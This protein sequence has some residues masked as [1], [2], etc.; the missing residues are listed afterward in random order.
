[1][2]IFIYVYIYMYIYTHISHD[3]PMKC[4]IN[5]PLNQQRGPPKKTTGPST[6]A[7]RGKAKA[8]PTVP[9]VPTVAASPKVPRFFPC[10]FF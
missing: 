2:Y 1:M 8:A 9:T 3:I 6:A 4:S 5:K 10:F 7:W